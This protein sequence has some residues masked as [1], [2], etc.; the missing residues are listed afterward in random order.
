MKKAMLI[1]LLLVAATSVFA[2]DAKWADSPEGYFLTKAERA[3][4][5]AISNTPAADTFIASFREKR[6]GEAF[7]KEL[8]TRVA[9]ADK[10]LSIGKVK[11]STTTR[12]KLVILFGAP[13][14][15]EI[16]DKK[17]NKN[18][19]GGASDMGGGGELGVGVSASNNMGSSQAI[20]SAPA[21]RL[22]KNYKFTF[23]GKNNAALDGQDLTVDV[24]VD[25]GTGK[26]RLDK[27]TATA[28][29][30]KFEAAA[31]ASIKK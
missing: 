27:K 14:G 22:M 31:Q 24:E 26:D 25:A 23:S 19:A 8:N 16:T 1:G 4:F 18:Y 13:A 29:E 28:L 20:G 15:M 5:E 6:G 10:Y 17:Q 12:G 11:G 30:P 2:A 7:T 21:G 9:M 3:E